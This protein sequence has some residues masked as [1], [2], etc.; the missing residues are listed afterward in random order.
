MTYEI[1]I[2]AL[3]E[4][5]RRYLAAVDTFRTVGCELAWRAE[6]PAGA[7]KEATCSLFKHD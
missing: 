7:G 5:I 1:D 4:E 3:V 2:T 6:Y